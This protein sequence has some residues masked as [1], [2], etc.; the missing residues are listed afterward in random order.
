MELDGE[1]FSNEKRTAFLG[2]LDLPHRVSPELELA[3]I[4]DEFTSSTDRVLLE[5][6]G[7]K[8]RDARDVCTTPQVFREYVQRSRGEFTCARPSAGRLRS[9]WVSDRTVCYLASGKPVVV[10]Y[11]APSRYMPEAGLVRFTTPAE[12][13]SS[14]EAVEQDY[15]HHSRLARA[16]AEEHFDATKIAG[17]RAGVNLLDS[18]TEPSEMVGRPESSRRRSARPREPRLAPPTRRL[19]T[20]GDPGSATGSKPRR[21]PSARF[22]RLALLIGRRG[23]ARPRSR[24]SRRFRTAT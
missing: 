16:V 23:R 10:E 21:H 9:T 7:W 3:I 5:Q 15:G 12:A 18:C 11:T 8:I 2:Y 20:N 14:I 4:L 17:A 13:T 22:M 24:P 19:Q 1:I 6:H